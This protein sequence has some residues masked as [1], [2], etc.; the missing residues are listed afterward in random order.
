VLD[1]GSSN[2]TILILNVSDLREV[3][4]LEDDFTEPANHSDDHWFASESM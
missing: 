1:P 3:L 2:E 4:N